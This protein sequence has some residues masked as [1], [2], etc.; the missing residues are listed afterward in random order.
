MVFVLQDSTEVTVVAWVITDV[1][2]AVIVTVPVF[3][4]LSISVVVS[5]TVLPGAVAVWRMQC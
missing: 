4:S 5:T 2:V 3:V 1:A